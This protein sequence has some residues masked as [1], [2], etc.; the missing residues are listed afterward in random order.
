MYMS[1]AVDGFVGGIFGTGANMFAESCIIAV[2]TP[3]SNAGVWPVKVFRTDVSIG[4]RVGLGVLA[5]VGANLWAV[6]MILLELII[7]LASL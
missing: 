2:V 6:T 4:L 7:M 3:L 1:F 5:K